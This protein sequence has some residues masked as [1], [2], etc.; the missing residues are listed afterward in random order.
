MAKTTTTINDAQKDLASRIRSVCMAITGPADDMADAQDALKVSADKVKNTGRLAIALEIAQLSHNE[1]WRGND[2]AVACEYARTMSNATD[3]TAKTLN[4]VISEMRLFANP[5][6]RALIPTLHDACN[7]AWENEATDMM[8]ADP[9]DKSSVPT[10][11]RNY[12]PRLYHLLAYVTRAVKDDKLEVYNSDDIVWW[13]KV[14]DPAMNPANT[15]KKVKS[16]L[17]QLDTIRA[18]YNVADLDAAS[19][20]L[21]GVDEKMLEAGLTR[22][23]HVQPGHVAP[24]VAPAPSPAPAPMLD[25]GRAGSSREHERERGRLRSRPG[26]RRSDE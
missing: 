6:V 2:I 3:K 13:A 25:G 19:D 22:P 14:N 11:V 15:A 5:K 16:L 7:Q 26:P 18:I 1:G 24:A 4:T 23:V 21:R 9:E 8:C 10:P 20:V 17:K 12:A